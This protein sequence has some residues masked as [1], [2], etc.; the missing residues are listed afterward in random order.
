MG[1][2]LGTPTVALGAGV[3]AEGL[4]QALKAKAMHTSPRSEVGMRPDAVP[5]T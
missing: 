1:V 5:L 2:E 3:G 4:A